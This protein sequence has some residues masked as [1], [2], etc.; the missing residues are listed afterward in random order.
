MK[1]NEIK[2]ILFPTDFS[3]DSI[4]SLEAAV[5]FA[6]KSNSR[7]IVLNVVDTP[8]NFNMENEPVEIDLI[9]NDL[10]NFS[11]NKLEILSKE[12]NIKHDVLIETATYTGE[13]T[14]SIT[15]AV[16]N[17][18]ADLVI[19]GTKI[20]KDLFFKSTSFNIV[21]NT[22]VPLLSLPSKQISKD[23]KNILFPFNEEFLTLK[24]ADDVL[25]FA[26]LFKS[27]IILLG[28]SPGDT[29]E[30]KQAIT[31]NLMSIKNM[32]DKHK[33]ESEVHFKS[34]SNYSKAILEYTSEHTIDLVT[35]VNN[36]PTALKENLTVLSAKEVINHS[37][38]PVL[39]IPV[40]E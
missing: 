7:L 13:T 24:K 34:D 28:I 11:K 18:N 19:M 30:S 32:L 3:D 6:K 17:F 4:Q 20:T 36:L 21:K 38:M 14:P 8:F 40:R 27:K 5:Q 33:I 2:T 9:L 23:F 26:K 25:R 29:L 15:R 35:I 31:N 10:V 16:M 22:S 12:I 37:S 1:T 39:T